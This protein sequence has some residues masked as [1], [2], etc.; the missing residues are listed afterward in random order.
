MTPDE[1]RTRLDGHTIMTPAGCW[2]WTGVQT[3]DGYGMASIRGHKWL[4][5]RFTFVT[6]NGFLPGVVMHTCDNPACWNP[7]H[8]RAGTHAENRADCC[9]KHRQAVGEH[10]GNAKLTTE[11]VS[12]IRAWHA[13][14][15]ATITDLAHIY[16]VSRRCV[17]DVI[18]GR[19]WRTA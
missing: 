13:R 19:N 11:A 12:N 3:R 1:L 5:H 2:Q 15:L 14:G 6:F 4:I 9:A 16:H 18:N 10:N 8:L 17:A 7:A